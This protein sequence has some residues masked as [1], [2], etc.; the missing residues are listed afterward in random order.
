V[1]FGFSLNYFMNFDYNSG[2]GGMPTA[3]G[4]SDTPP[5]YVMD[6]RLSSE[7]QS[8]QASS[9][10]NQ[11]K[12]PNGFM[13]AYV[14]FDINKRPTFATPEAAKA[15]MNTTQYAQLKSMLLSVSYK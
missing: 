11:I 14:K 2:N 4:R 10:T 12:M 6:I 15:W 5:A 13:M 8:G 1:E 3:T 9:G 7:L